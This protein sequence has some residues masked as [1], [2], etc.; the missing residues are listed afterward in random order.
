MAPR[1]GTVTVTEDTGTPMSPL[2]REAV[3]AAAEQAVAAA[4]K[5]G[6]YFAVNNPKA[7]EKE[8]IENVTHETVPGH[9]SRDLATLQRIDKIT[10]AYVKANELKESQSGVSYPPVADARQ[11]PTGPLATP[12]VSKGTDPQ[13]N[14]RSRI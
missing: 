5:S 1:K 8:F 14:D 6:Q 4:K 7:A 3:D 10:E 9:M 12:H 13:K 2:Q 11:Q